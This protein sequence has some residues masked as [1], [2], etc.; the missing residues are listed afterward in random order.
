MFIYDILVYSNYE[1]QHEEHLRIVLGMFCKEKLYSK[2]KKY[3]FWIDRV[4]FL[5]HVVTS[6]EINVNLAEVEVIIE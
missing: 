6:R 2:F 1:R 5:G 4:V 3:E